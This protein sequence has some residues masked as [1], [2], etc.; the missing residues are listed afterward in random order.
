M[1]KL[2]LP[3]ETVI[4]TGIFFEQITEA[5]NRGCT[6]NWNSDYSFATLILDTTAFFT[7]LDVI[8]IIN[9][10]GEV[11]GYTMRVKMTV[12]HYNTG[13]VPLEFEEYNEIGESII[14]KKTYKDVFGMA[15][16]FTITNDITAPEYEVIMSSNNELLK[17]SDVIKIINN[18]PQ[19]TI[20]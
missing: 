10:G 14:V 2:T 17:C 3:R 15:I 18:D 9:S 6:L 8:N 1:I 12:D 13:I 11:E 7:D 16:P 5:A 19:V 4:K 20:I